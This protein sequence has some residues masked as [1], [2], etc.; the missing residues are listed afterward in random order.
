MGGLKWFHVGMETFPIGVV[1]S[2][3]GDLLL[4]TQRRVVGRCGSF[5]RDIKISSSQKIIF[6]NPKIIRWKRF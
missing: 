1:D 5:T 6:R 3:I 4:L 2:R